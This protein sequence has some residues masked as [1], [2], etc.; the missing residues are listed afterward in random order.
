MINNKYS[1][2]INNYDNYNY[3]LIDYLKISAIDFTKLCE[4]CNSSATGTRF[5]SKRSK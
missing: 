3:R 4:N 5:I 1:F 2:L